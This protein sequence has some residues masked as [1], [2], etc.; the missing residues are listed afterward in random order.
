M[1]KQIHQLVDLQDATSTMRDWNEI[2][3]SCGDDPK[4]RN[5]GQ[6]KLRS[7]IGLLLRIA[8]LA[9]ENAPLDLAWFDATFPRRPKFPL[10]VKLKTY[11]DA[12]HRVRPMVRR[13]TGHNPKIGSDSWDSLCDDLHELFGGKRDADLKLIPVSSTLSNAARARRI[14][15]T[16]MTQDILIELHKAAEGSAERLSIRK[17]SQLLSDAQ[18]IFPE[19]AARLPH[20]LE[21]ICADES[22]RYLVP[23]QLEREIDALEEKAARKGFIEIMEERE[24]VADGTRIGVCTALRALVDGFIRSKC[25]DPEAD[26]FLHLLHDREALK[27]TIRVQVE[28]VRRGEI[29]PRHAATLVRRI[30]VVLDRNGISSKE[31]RCQIAQVAELKAPRGGYKMPKKTKRFCRALIEEARHRQ[32]FLSA[33]DILRKKAD[34][35]LAS[36]K[37]RNNRL[38]P[39]QKRQVIQMGT[40]ALF[41]AIETGG[42]PVR[43]RNVLDMPYKEPDGWLRPTADGFRVTIPASHVKNHREIGFNITRGP[44]AYAET[45]SWYL[46]KVRP[47]ILEAAGAARSDWLVPMLTDPSRSCRY[48]TFLNWFKR[49]MTREVELP[50]TPHNFRHGQASLLY[51]AYPEHLDLIARRLGDTRGTVTTYY[52]WVHEELAMAEG[53]M[54][55]TGLLKE[56]A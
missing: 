21:P 47:L 16:G 49:L 23:F 18:A 25:L 46:E 55:L 5:A 31:I 8:E 19:V 54:L 56:A 52:A 35:V 2:V 24:T 29:V 10:P 40:V 6:K 27:A 1:L 17:A 7:A 32:S 26:S 50:C 12:R 34:S 43:V 9:P 53:Q 48:E 38:T 11:A 41:C 20:L 39:A 14:Q 42:A 30:P 44:H 28:R 13:L 15:P 4:D 36:A 51:Y 33:H 22:P 3:A 45:V 37:R